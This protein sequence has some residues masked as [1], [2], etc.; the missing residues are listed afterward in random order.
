MLGSQLILQVVAKLYST[1]ATT[2]YISCFHQISVLEATSLTEHIKINLLRM[3]NFLFPD[4][5][6]V[7]PSVTSIDNRH[8][9]QQL[10]GLD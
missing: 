10:K 8:H 2:S 7:I 4:L 1:T 6:E 5:I 9:Y 3:G